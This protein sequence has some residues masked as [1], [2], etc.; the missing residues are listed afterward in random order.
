MQ[1]EPIF[2]VI[3]VNYRS[4]DL[5][6]SSI[7]SLPEPWQREII[8]VNNDRLEEMKLEALKAHIP[9]TLVSSGGNIGF[10]AACNLGALRARGKYLFF[11][12]PDTLW[13][14]GVFSEMALF[15]EN[16][17]KVAVVGAK[18]VDGSGFPEQWGAGLPLSFF[19]LAKNN[20]GMPSGKH[21]WE[22]A[23]PTGSGWVSGAAMFVRKDIFETIGGF[24]ERFFLYFEDVDI[25]QRVRTIGK[26]VA[27]YPDIVIRHQGG[28]SHATEF[29]K[30]QEF[31]RS[32]RRYFE[33]HRPKDE[34][35]A[36]SLL[37][38]FFTGRTKA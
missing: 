14:W 15:F 21:I 2:S 29:L 16:H 3:F 11:L 30:K 26:A 19:E 7:Q 34:Q 17:P 24:D 27:F 22:S 23:V 35:L 1:K 33:K 28:A 31:Y 36:L 37:Q 32:Q 25:S 13:Q 38:Y 5:L 10:G 18:I 8:V 4:A 12:N 9:L 6:C 20:I